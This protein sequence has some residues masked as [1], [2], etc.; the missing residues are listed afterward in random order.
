LLRTDTLNLD[1]NEED[2]YIGL[3]YLRDLYDFWHQRGNSEKTSWKLSLAS[4]NAG[5]GRVLQYKGIPPFTETQNFVAFIS[6][7]HS[8]PVFLANYTRKYDN[9]YKGNS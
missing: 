4:Y 6:K 7:V 8:N 3:T 5:K 9:A 2:I 1:K